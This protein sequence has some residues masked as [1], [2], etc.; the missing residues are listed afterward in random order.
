[1]CS[2]IFKTRSLLT[3]GEA[4]AGGPAWRTII[5]V[6]AFC[7]FNATLVHRIVDGIVGNVALI[8]EVDF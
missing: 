4:E 6:E 7:G 1:M 8:D 3:I 2:S 5:G